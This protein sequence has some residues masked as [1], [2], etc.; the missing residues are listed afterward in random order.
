[1]RWLGRTGI[2]GLLLCSILG[3]VALPSAPQSPREAGL[4]ARQAELDVLERQIAEKRREIAR[5]RAEGQEVETLLAAMERE[6]VMAERYLRTLEEQQRE[7]ARDIE[8]RDTALGRLATELERQRRGLATALLH[9]YR[10]E[11]VSAAELLVS[12]ESFGEI[13]ARAH[14]WGRTV[15][16]LAQR[17]ETVDAQRR[18]WEDARHELGRRRQRLVRLHREREAALE[19]MR[20]EEAERR[21]Y[22]AQLDAQIERYE[23]QTRKLIATQEKIARLIAEAERA[24][25]AAGDGLAALRGALRWPVR[26]PLVR[27]FGTRVH[28]KYGTRVRHKGIVIAADEGQPIRAVAAGRVVFVGWL[29]G[30]GRTVILDHGEGWFTIYAHASATLVGQGERIGMGTEVARVGSTDSLEGPG[31]HFEIRQGA[32]ALDPAEFLDPQG[33]G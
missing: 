16:R 28:P 15:Q 20:R 7:L 8:E 11:R 12:S 23:E 13:F 6:R 27:G 32:E 33:G 1:M 21:R 26:G 18:E 10:Q 29:E 30:Y 2:A 17:V 31:V 25:A 9:Y 24:A 5:L 19:R 4:A 22:R 14:Y 3:L